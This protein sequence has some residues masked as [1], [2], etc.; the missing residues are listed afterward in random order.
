MFSY[1]YYLLLLILNVSLIF[2]AAQVLIPR[3]S[4]TD[5]Y[6][7]R[8]FY[9]QL[10]TASISTLLILLLPSLLADRIGDTRS[11]GELLGL[12]LFLIALQ[13]ADYA[14][15]MEHINGSAQVAA[16][17]SVIVYGA[18]ILL[19]LLLRPENSEYVLWICAVSALPPVA[20]HLKKTSKVYIKHYSS[21][22]FLDMGDHLRFSRSLIGTATLSSAW[23]FFP[24]FMLGSLMGAASVAILASIRSLTNVANVV[25][26]YIDVSLIAP[27][28]CRANKEGVGVLWPLLRMIMLGG[29]MIFALG[30]GVIFILGD[31]I[32]GTLLGKDYGGYANVL[33][34]VWV[35]YAIYFIGRIHALGY[36]I[37]LN[38]RVEFVGSIFSATAAVLCA[39][40]LIKLLGIEGA[41]LTYMAVSLAGLI[42]Q[43][44]YAKSKN[45]RSD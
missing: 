7:A 40:P 45:A 21:N 26:E 29:G 16:Y 24:V 20:W 19:L 27:L 32:L 17:G 14:R 2:Q 25:M 28:A 12:G 13:L 43:V 44:S 34:I 38:S 22:I 37:A 18:R 39:Y 5:A 4:S 1:I 8:L 31:Q 30:G 42:A 23:S 3:S 41:A 15:R 10:Y 33:L 35:S 6:R 36:R 9:L 11:H